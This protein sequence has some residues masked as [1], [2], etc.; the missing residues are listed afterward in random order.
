[1][2]AAEQEELV[3]GVEALLGEAVGQPRQ[4]ESRKT[5]TKVVR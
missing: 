3:A 4:A 5:T 1:M 2:N